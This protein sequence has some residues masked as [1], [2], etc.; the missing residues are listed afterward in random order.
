[1]L[2][3][4]QV[5]ASAKIAEI[6]LSPCAVANRKRK[7][8]PPVEPRALALSLLEIIPPRTWNR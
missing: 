5:A 7:N 3:S 1:M 2:L 4:A 6:R 8:R